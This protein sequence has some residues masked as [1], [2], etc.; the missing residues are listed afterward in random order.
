MND[1]PKDHLVLIKP[2]QQW[3]TESSVNCQYIILAGPYRNDLPGI[4]APCI[5]KMFTYYFFGA[6]IEVVSIDRNGQVHGDPRDV[7]VEDFQKFGVNLSYALTIN[8]VSQEILSTN[9]FVY[10]FS[11]SVFYRTHPDV[12]SNMYRA[13][14][15]STGFVL[16]LYTINGAIVYAEL[17][18]VVNES[19]AEYKYVVRPGYIVADRNVLKCLVPQ[20]QEDFA[21]AKAVLKQDDIDKL[22]EKLGVKV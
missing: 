11:Q 7:K 12:V 16:R 17:H 20:T 2:L 6:T 14:A 13:M 21:D 8:N 3:T 5:T 22:F 18:D 1:Q 9:G 15:L 10:K 4:I 19:S